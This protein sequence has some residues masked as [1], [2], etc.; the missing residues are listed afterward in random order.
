MAPIK[1]SRPQVSWQFHEKFAKTFGID[2]CPVYSVLGSV[3]SQ[4]FI[5]IISQKNLPAVNWFYYDSEKSMGEIIQLAAQN[6]DRE[7]RKDRPDL[8]EVEKKNTK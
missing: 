2:F 1:E 3:L 4:E 7:V 8:R 6:K 5:K